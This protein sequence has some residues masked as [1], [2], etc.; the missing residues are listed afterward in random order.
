MYAT[1][2]MS[3]HFYPERRLKINL[4]IISFLEIRKLKLKRK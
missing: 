2:F 4:I 1:D 3:Y